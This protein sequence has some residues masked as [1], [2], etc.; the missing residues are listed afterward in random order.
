MLCTD[1][2]LV[3]EPRLH[4]IDEY[5]GRDHDFIVHDSY[6]MSKVQ[7]EIEF[8]V[9]LYFKAAQRYKVLGLSRPI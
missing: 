5:T 8:L 1:C 4:V 9:Y 2:M 7:Q 6:D 3:L